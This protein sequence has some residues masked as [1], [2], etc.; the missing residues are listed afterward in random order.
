MHNS[1][2]N[3]GKLSFSTCLS[4]QVACLLV[5]EFWLRAVDKNT[6][7]IISYNYTKLVEII[8][9]LILAT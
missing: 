8:I 9:Y 1:F 4:S 5:S 7:K 2:K 6:P 3:N